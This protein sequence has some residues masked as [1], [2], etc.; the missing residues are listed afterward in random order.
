VDFSRAFVS[1]I[2]AGGKDAYKLALTRHIQ[3]EYLYGD[4]R[5][6][7]EYLIGH[8]K[9]Y[10]EIPS[11]QVILGKTG[12]DIGDPDGKADFYVSECLELRLHTL[13]KEHMGPVSSLIG[14]NKAKEAFAEVQKLVAAVTQSQ[15]THA[16]ARS[17]FEHVPAVLELYNQMKSGKMGIPMPFPS[18]NTATL[19]MWPQDLILFAARLG[20]GKTWTMLLT[21]REAWKSGA[22]VLLC[23][24]EMGQERIAQRFFALDKKL[25][26]GQFR[27]GALP[28]AI[29]N[30]MYEGLIKMM[31]KDDG[32]LKVLGGDFDFN[33]DNL[34]AEIDTA[35]PDLVI[36]D[37]AYLIRSKGDNRTEQAAN[38]FNDLKRIANST[39]IPFVVSSQFNREVKK[40]S[41][42]TVQIESVGLTDVA[43][44][45]ADVSFGLV[46]TEDM[47]RDKRMIFKPLKIREGRGDEFEVIWDIDNMHFEEL[48]KSAE[49]MSFDPAAVMDNVVK[50]PGG[51]KNDEPQGGPG[52]LF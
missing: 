13:L 36:V 47:S 31:E 27:R 14:E 6:A 41:P 43:G 50:F 26:Y 45:N 35:L 15:L 30:A 34:R 20:I 25:P 2:V 4:G 51:N 16:P 18:M 28:L 11:R 40:N 32:R 7:W 48:P 12:V 44:W 5:F 49:G 9:D 1:S 21:A 24:T 10:G 42:G 29:E 17:I 39:K 19:G 52:D 46:Q 8:V 3:P 33:M 38:T 23:T 37:G 22:R